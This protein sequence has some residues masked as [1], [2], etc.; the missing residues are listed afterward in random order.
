MLPSGGVFLGLRRPGARPSEITLDDEQDCRSI[1]SKQEQTGAPASLSAPQL[2]GPQICKPSSPRTLDPVPCFHL[3]GV[4]GQC[5]Q[6]HQLLSLV[7]RLPRAPMGCVL[8]LTQPPPRA[9]LAKVLLL[10]EP[11]SGEFLMG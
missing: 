2:S 7:T 1:I 5:G 11:S 10:P 6:C 4:A 9:N 3:S 8:P